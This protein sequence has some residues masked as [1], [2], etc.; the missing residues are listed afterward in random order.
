VQELAPG[1]FQL[2]GRPRN[3]INV[4][5]AGD[6]LIDA[7]TRHARR[8]IMRQIAGRQVTAHALTHAHPDHQGASHAVCETL[9]IPLWCGDADTFAMETKG[10]I[11]RLQHPGLV[12][13]LQQLFW[14][15]PPHPVARRLR[16]G[17]EVAGF[18]VLE[19]PGHS[20]GHVARAARGLHARPDPQPRLDPPPRGAGTA[21]VLLRARSAAA[22]SRRA[23]AVRR[24]APGGLTAARHRVFAPCGISVPSGRAPDPGQHSGALVAWRERP[25]RRSHGTERTTA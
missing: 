2:D 25:T 11:G 4:Y 15:G 12:N 1:V 14:T 17:D 18:E 16:E 23:R 10:E 19:V 9:G 6:V 20:P 13:R 7:G 8:R 24:G 3:A 22:R 21:P 5:L